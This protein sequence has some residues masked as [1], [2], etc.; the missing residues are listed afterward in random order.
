M[1][2]ST[3]LSTTARAKP[4][5]TRHEPYTSQLIA[6]HC[7]LRC[8]AEITW[9]QTEIHFILNCVLLFPL[10]S[11]ALQHNP[12]QLDAEWARTHSDEEMLHARIIEAVRSELLQRSSDVV[13]RLSSEVNFTIYHD[14]LR[15]L[16]TDAYGINCTEA[17]KKGNLLCHHFAEQYYA[18]FVVW[19]T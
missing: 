5:A 16:M 3:L 9:T 15:S 4:H 8:T 6:I 13:R 12:V 10:F 19:E 14:A 2:N 18:K 17:H 7:P 11:T 1:I